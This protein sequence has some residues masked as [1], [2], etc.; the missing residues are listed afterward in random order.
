VRKPTSDLALKREKGLNGM[1]R[2]IEW[3]SEARATELGREFGILERQTQRGAFRTLA[4]NPALAKPIYDIVGALLTQNSLAIR[5]R[6]MIV[7]RIA[8][9]T[10]SEYQWFQHYLIATGEAGL[11]DEDVVAVRD[12]SK[13]ARLQ[14]ADRAVLAA[15]DD[16][17]DRGSISDAVWAQCSEHVREPSVQVEMAVAISYW[18]MLSQ[19]FKTFQI[20]L[21]AGASLWPP[22]GQS[23]VANAIMD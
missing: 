23:P 21:Q 14:A 16:T 19:L 9:R 10:G 2:R 4:N 6:E 18:I 22:D 17:I 15:V 8:W 7:L 5:L 13:S 1:R 3:I 11:S 12:W 20:P